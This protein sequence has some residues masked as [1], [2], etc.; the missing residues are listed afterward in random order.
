MVEKTLP[1]PNYISGTFE[2]VLSTGDG[3]YAAPVPYSLPGGVDVATVL[4]GDFNGDGKPDLLVGG[5]QDKALHLFLN[6]GFGGFSHKAAFPNWVL[7]DFTSV[8][9]D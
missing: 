3:R 2:V 7:G 9:G 6:N 4:I 5:E 8:V 1:A